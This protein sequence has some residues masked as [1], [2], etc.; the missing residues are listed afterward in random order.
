MSFTYTNQPGTRTI[1]TI[2]F[3]VDDKTETGHVLSDEE[4]QYLIDNNASTLHAAAAAADTIAGTF[5]RGGMTEKQVGDLRIRYDDPAAHYATLAKS[6]RRRAATKAA[7]Y[8]GGLSTSDKD[9]MVADT[10]RT[11]IVLIPGRDSDT[12]SGGR[13]EDWRY[14]VD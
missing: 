12:G 8:A 4:I 11:R 3:E 13:S 2:R 10:D 7:P 5:A 14:G 1:D 6:L 9:T